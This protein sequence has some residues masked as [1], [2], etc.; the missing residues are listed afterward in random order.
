MACKNSALITDSGCVGISC[1]SCRVSQGSHVDID[2]ACYSLKEG[3]PRAVDA[4]LRDVYDRRRHEQPPIFL[5]IPL[6]AVAF[7]DHRLWH[8]GVPNGSDAFRQMVSL[9]Y[10]AQFLY[11]REVWTSG[12]EAADGAAIDRRLLFSSDCANAFSRPSKYGV[13][14]NVRFVDG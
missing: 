10:S 1:K 6:S 7:R 2:A 5:E 14:R 13:D 12:G 9:N 8:R 4:Q 3:A 11:E